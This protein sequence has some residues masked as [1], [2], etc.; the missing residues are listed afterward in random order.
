MLEDPQWQTQCHTHI[1]QVDH[2]ANMA[3]DRS[4]RQKEV[5]I[6]EVLSFE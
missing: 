3:F 6:T 2:G 1:R 4:S 5:C